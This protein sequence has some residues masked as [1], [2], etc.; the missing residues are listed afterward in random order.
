M[1]W[2]GGVWYQFLPDLLPDLARLSFHRETFKTS[3]RTKR[4]NLVFLSPQIKI[5]ARR[6]SRR[7][8]ADQ[9]NL[10]I[11]MDIHSAE[12][13]LLAWNI[14]K[15]FLWIFPI[16]CSKNI[17]SILFQK[18]LTHSSFKEFFWSESVAHSSVSL[19]MS[20]GIAWHTSKLIVWQIRDKVLKETFTTSWWMSDELI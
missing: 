1:P 2:V 16:F 19:V 14:H 17:Q 18:R 7:V 15:Y 20:N 12:L 10:I 9:R 13:V 8:F 3:S 5:S 4:T 11:H 6:F